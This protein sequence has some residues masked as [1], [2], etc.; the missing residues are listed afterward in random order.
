MLQILAGVAWLVTAMG[1]YLI[2][3]SFFRSNG[4][5]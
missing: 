4:P 3:S 5:Q 1:M 2:I